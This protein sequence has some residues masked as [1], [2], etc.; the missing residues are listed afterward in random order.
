MMPV[1]LAHGRYPPCP[2]PP[3]SLI[4]DLAKASVQKKQG[5]TEVRTLTTTIV[6]EA[7]GGRG[8]RPDRFIRSARVHN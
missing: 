7:H 8:G 3:T 6:N 1:G 5:T 4:G 2:L